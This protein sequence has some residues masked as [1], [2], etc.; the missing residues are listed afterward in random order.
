MMLAASCLATR[1]ILRLVQGFLWSKNLSLPLT[2]TTVPS[3]G[4]GRKAFSTNNRFPG[5]LQIILGP[6]N[7][8][9]LVENAAARNK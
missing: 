9:S 7:A 2:D 1:R 6:K 5:S 4:R 8:L 3:L